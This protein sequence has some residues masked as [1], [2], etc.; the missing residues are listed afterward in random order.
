MTATNNTPPLPPDPLARHRVV[1]SGPH[2][3]RI[4]LVAA[5]V[6][7]L[8]LAA[9]M[10]GRSQ[11]SGMS[12]VMGSLELPRGESKL[13][14]YEDMVPKP[15]PAPPPAPRFE[16]KEP[17]PPPARP[18]ARPVPKEDD[19]RKKA[20][21]AGVGGWSRK[22]N[23]KDTEPT[24]KAGS[25][26]FAAAGADCLVPP[27][28][29][30]PLLTVNR[31]VTERGGIVTA[32]VT[33]DI[34]DAGFSCLAVPAGSMVTLEVGTGVG[35]GQKRIAVANP[36]ITRPWPRNDTVRVAAVGADATGAAGLA[37]SVDVPWFQTGLLIAASTAVDVGV[38][39]LTGGGS[40]I[41]GILGHAMDRPL[42]KAAKDL[43]DRAS[44]I[45][46]D[47]GEPVLLLLRGGLRADDFG[48]DR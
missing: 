18:Q 41:G 6:I 32:R 19:L 9:Y 12:K 15:P 35:R 25:S 38:A 7:G 47:A 14:G 2:V 46:L 42:D 4:L 3:V 17:P 44:V 24:G 48:R 1:T 22:E 36:L 33:L 10:L 28:T 20:M 40:L 45:T 30:I 13:P 31:V 21:E 34:W 5:V 16:K 37:G 29:P 39:A 26:D 8:G 23:G 11:G 27:G 43:L